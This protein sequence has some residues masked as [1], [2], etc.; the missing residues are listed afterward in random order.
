MANP[1]IAEAVKAAVA[2]D[3]AAA[4]AEGAADPYDTVITGP[5]MGRW[6]IVNHN[7]HVTRYLENKER[8]V[9]SEWHAHQ[10]GAFG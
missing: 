1:V 8:G 2:A 3:A 9:S 7:K 4:P 6:K 10:G 5:W